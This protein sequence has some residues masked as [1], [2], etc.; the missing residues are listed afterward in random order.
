MTFL[1]KRLQADCRDHPKRKILIPSA[2]ENTTSSESLRNYDVL[3]ML[4]LARCS[5]LPKTP[6]NA[7]SPHVSVMIPVY[8]GLDTLPRAI[9][10]LE[11]QTFQDWEAIIVNDGSTDEVSEFLATLQDA[12]IRV[13]HHQKNQGRAAARQTALDAVRGKFVAYLDCDDFYHPQKLERQLGVFQKSPDVDYCSCGLGSF[14][15][16]CRLR[17]VRASLAIDREYYRFGKKLRL[18]PGASIIRATVA[19]KV[20]YNLRLNLGEDTDFFQRALDGRAFA[21]IP[22]VL[23]YYGEYDSVTNAKILRSYLYSARAASYYW[24]VDRKFAIKSFALHFGKA[25]SLLAVYPF[26]NVERILD[27]RGIEPSA[28]DKEE[29]AWVLGKIGSAVC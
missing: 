7:K 14:D 23:Y 12:R 22:D 9:K 28:R 10:S 8:N 20:R 1:R 21:A 17:R 27:G 25:L 13:L 29:F 24:E 5:V 18:S 11:L 2:D 3:A 26:V 16:R 6:M 19:K 15:G 4:H